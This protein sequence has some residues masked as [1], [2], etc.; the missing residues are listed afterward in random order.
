MLKEFLPKKSLVIIELAKYMLEKKQGDRI[1]PIDYFVSKHNW[2]RGTVQN[3]FSYLKEIEAIS[4]VRQG[5]K[6][7]FIKKMDYKKL[8]E[9]TGIDR[10]LGA[11]PLPY[12]TTY[13]GL[14]TGL[15]E[16]GRNHSLPITLIY[17]RG[18]KARLDMLLQEKCDFIIMSQ[19]AAQAAIEMDYHIK[20]VHVF[21][22]K[23]YTQN[24][25]VLL[26]AD[27]NKKKLE[28]GMLLGYDALSLDLKVLTNALAKGV[29][30]QYIDMMYHQ[31]IKAVTE[32]KIDA[33]IWN[34]DE[35]IEK[36]LDINYIPLPKNIGM[37]TSKAVI[38]VL[39]GKSMGNILSQYDMDLIMQ[40]QKEVVE[41]HRLPAY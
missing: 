36:K 8:F 4:I 18:A 21:E 16:A 41:G 25:H 29:N 39:E 27:K 1:A 30:V 17:M 9:C 40:T 6:G 23:S 38:A 10:I 20:V 3:A 5:C 12:S 13:E 19:I 31:L 28:D 34:A 2:T 24:P 15:Y 11:M 26:L 7:S 33:A 37:Q 32:G 14:A 35:I 22:E